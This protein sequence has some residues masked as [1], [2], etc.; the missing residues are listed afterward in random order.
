VSESGVGGLVGKRE[1]IAR[2]ALHLF[3]RDGYTR[4]S[5]DAIAADARV[6]KRTVYNHYADKEQLF[7]SVVQETQQTLRAGLKRILDETLEQ[8]GD[9]E[10]GLAAFAQASVAFMM[11]SPDRT[12]LIRLMITEAPHFPV[13]LDQHAR[14][15]ALTSAL[16]ERLTLLAA[17]GSLDITDPAEAAGHFVALVFDRLNLRSVF[18]CIEL[19]GDEVDRLVS[20]GVRVFLSAYRPPAVHREN[21]RE[22]A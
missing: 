17:D 1:A 18:G 9:V 7:L 6:S 21:G 19:S 13:L 3:V 5:V 8:G 20:S 12:A 4:T 15:Q 2:S 11:G 16:T 10:Q 22:K 14:S